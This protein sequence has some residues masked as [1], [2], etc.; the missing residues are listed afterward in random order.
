MAPEQEKKKKKVFQEGY[1][2]ASPKNEITMR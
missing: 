1:F 2:V